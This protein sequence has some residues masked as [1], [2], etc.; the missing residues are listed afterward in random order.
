[1]FVNPYPDLFGNY[2]TRTFAEIFPTEVDFINEW[3]AAPFADRTDSQGE[4]L[5]AIPANYIQLCYWLLVTRYA[6]STIASFD[7]NQFKYKVFNIIFTHGPTWIKRLEVQNKI[8]NLSEEELTRGS[9][10]INNSALHPGTDPSTATLEELTA[11]DQQTTSNRKKSVLE[12]Y[13]SL[14]ALLQVDV[15][16]EFVDKFKKLFITVVQPNLPLWYIT[17]EGEPTND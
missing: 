15:S 14:L 12:A 16:E 5:N 3:N 10:I 13:S 8:R 6:N 2:P 1:M 7:E 17:K 4:P 11:I 9:K